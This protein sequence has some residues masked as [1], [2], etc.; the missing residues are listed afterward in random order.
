MLLWTMQSCHSSSRKRNKTL[1]ANSNILILIGQ[2]WE[3][4]HLLF[5]S[6]KDKYLLW[7]W[8]LRDGLLVSLSKDRSLVRSTHTQWFTTACKSSSS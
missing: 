4:V 8:G 2:V 5:L 7:K 3:G 1:G 6:L